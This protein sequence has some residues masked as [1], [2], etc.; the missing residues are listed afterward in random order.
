MFHTFKYV[1]LP[2]F[3]ASWLGFAVFGVILMPITH[4]KGI[5]FFVCLA[6]AIVCFI[7]FGYQC[8]KAVTHMNQDASRGSAL[9]EQEEREK[10]GKEHRSL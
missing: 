4:G 8:L 6:I 7:L 1:N 9:R 10:H 5:W 3:I 2:I